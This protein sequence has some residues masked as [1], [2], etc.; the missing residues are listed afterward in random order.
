[1]SLPLIRMSFKVE[2][3]V[4]YFINA[5]GEVGKTGTIKVS[6]KTTIKPENQE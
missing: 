4:K 1:M 3:G 6:L 5:S 2:T